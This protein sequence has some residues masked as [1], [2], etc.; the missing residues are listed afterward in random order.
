MK[1]LAHFDAVWTRC[2]LLTTL[3]AYFVKNAS[4]VLQPDQLLRAA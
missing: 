2:A 1:A 3:R 4:G